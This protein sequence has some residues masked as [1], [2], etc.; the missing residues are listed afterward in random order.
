[1]FWSP[2]ISCSAVLSVLLVHAAAAQTATPD[3]AFL[4]QSRALTEQRYAQA[5]QDQSRLYNGTEYVNYARYYQASVGNQF[6]VSEQEALGAVEYDGN[7][8]Q[9]VPLRYDLRLDQVIIKQPTSSFYVQ[10]VPERVKQFTV[11]GHRFVRLEGDSSTQSVRP[12]FYDVLLDKQVKVFARRTKQMQTQ[13]SQNV[14]KAEF[15]A[16]TQYYIQTNHSLHAVKGKGSVVSL[17]PARR[18]ELQRYAHDNHLTFS[19]ETREQDIIRLADF[20]T[21]LPEASQAGGGSY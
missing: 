21:S 13:P 4:S 3:S 16:F 12:G 14:T 8:Y 9:N 18:K 1:M 17:F 7:W 6:F 2:P 19:K 5:I 20:Y 11:H 15:Y 10:L